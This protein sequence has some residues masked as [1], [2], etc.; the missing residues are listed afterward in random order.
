MSAVKDNTEIIPLERSKSAAIYARSKAVIPHGV[1]S[2][3]RAFPGLNQ[4]PMV[5]TSGYGD[6]ITDADGYSYIDYCCSWGALLH[7]HAH[8]LVVEGAQKRCAMGS[9]FG[10]TT[11][12]EAQLAAKVVELVPAIEKV[13]FVSSGTEA[14][15]SALRL[16][17]GF[18]GRDLVIKFVGNYH[19]HCDSLLVQAGSGVANLSA[20]S[21]AGVPE[22]FVKHT[23]CLPYNDVE[24]VR[25]VLQRK[26]VRDNLAAVILE[27]VAA[28]MGVVPATQ[29]F[30]EMLRE[31]TSECSA[32][33]IFD[34]VITG[35]RVALGGAEELYGVRPDLVCLGKIVGGGFPAAAFGGSEEVMQHIAP[36]GPVYQAG[37]LSGNPVAMEAGYQTLRIAEQEGFY[38]ELEK[39]ATAITK[40]VSE[41]I[42]KRGIIAC[43]QQVGSLFTLF[44]GRK[45]VSHFE[46]AKSCDHAL[47]NTFFQFMFQRG[48]YLSPS[49]YE[50]NF[51]SSAH[52]A[53]SLEKTR[54]LILEFLCEH[55]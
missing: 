49:Q 13:R 14:A 22:D 37:T 6:R 38:S 23:L 47:F 55:F 48:V 50:A 1:N 44:F 15:M 16:A 31:E 43:V 3:V 40:P 33:L 53:E 5:V 26:A 20:S 30:I 35:F 21:S 12:I 27:P 28:N 45:K 8:S 17:R 39:R 2:P 36:L 4:T 41:C 25:A 11:E 34:E 32:L 52:T 7:G 9:S 18:T 19:G 42:Q 54:D 29:A 46:D 10:I 24:G 51:V